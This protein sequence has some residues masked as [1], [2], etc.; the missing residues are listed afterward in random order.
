MTTP[1]ELQ[2]LTIGDEIRLTANPVAEL[3]SMH[4]YSFKIS[5]DKD[6]EIVI[7]DEE[8][9]LLITFNSSTKKLSID[10]SAAWYPELEDR[11][12]IT[13][14]IEVPEFTLRLVVYP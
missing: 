1:R 9:Y 10:R 2:L 8:R 7:G 5:N 11:P 13:P 4:D 12:Q 3:K 6:V 14:M